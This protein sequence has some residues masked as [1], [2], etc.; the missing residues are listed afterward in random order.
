MT[1]RNESYYT[2]YLGTPQEFISTIKYGYL[3][4]GQWYAWHQKPRGTPSLHL[5]PSAF[6]NFLQNH[7]QIANSAHGLRLHK[8]TDPGNYRA[9][10]ALLLLVPETPM[11]FQ[12]QEFASSSPFYYFADHT[13]EL[14][15]LIF[16]G[17]REF[18]KQFASI[19]TPEI[20]ARLPEPSN[21]ETFKKCKLNFLD[22]EYHSQEYAL[23]RDLLRIRRNDSVFS[24]P[25]FEELTELF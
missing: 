10:T 22:R 19:A 1:G 20:Q 3:Y 8:L 12:G 15:E 7:D 25:R 11:L 13:P 24:I 6:I 21:P 9:I 2:D 4:Q 14:A 23:H 18:F 5:N 16:K 17:R